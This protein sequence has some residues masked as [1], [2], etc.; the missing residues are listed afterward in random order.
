MKT[1]KGIELEGICKESTMAHSR[2]LEE[3]QGMEEFETGQ[4]P[5]GGAFGGAI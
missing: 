3:N 1:Y 5:E 2:F 4:P